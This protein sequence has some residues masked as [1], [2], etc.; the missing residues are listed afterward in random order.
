MRPLGREE[1]PIDPDVTPRRPRAGHA[2]CVAGL[3]AP[4]FAHPT[5]TPPMAP[6][7]PRALVTV[8]SHSAAGSLFQVIP[9]P[10][11]RVSRRPSATKVLIAMLVCIAPSGPIQPIAP[12]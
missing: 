1:P 8:S 12:V 5:S 10:T 9:P 11:W 3:L 4:R 7:G 2:A 6:S